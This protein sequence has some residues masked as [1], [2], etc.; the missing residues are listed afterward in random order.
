VRE[1]KSFFS[2]ASRTIENSFQ[3]ISNTFASG[4]HELF[5]DYEQNYFFIRTTMTEPSKPYGFKKKN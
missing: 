2:S 3:E 1:E 5:G 4:V